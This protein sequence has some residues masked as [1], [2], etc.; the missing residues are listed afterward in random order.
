MGNKVESQ[1]SSLVQDLDLIT[2]LSFYFGR[3]ALVA[4]VHMHHSLP[5]AVCKQMDLTCMFIELHGLP[6][7]LANAGNPV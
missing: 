2:H 1:A 6:A 7:I 3:T 4:C 5:W